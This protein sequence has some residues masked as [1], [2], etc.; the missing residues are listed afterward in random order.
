MGRWRPWIK[1]N[2]KNVIEKLVPEPFPSSA[3][4]ERILH[5]YYI[6]MTR[7]EPPRGRAPQQYAEDT[8]DDAQRKAMYAPENAEYMRERFEYSYEKLKSVAAD[9]YGIAKSAAGKAAQYAEDTLEDAEGKAQYAKEKLN[10]A[11]TDAYVKA[12]SAADTWDNAQRKAKYAKEKLSDTATAAG[13]AYEKSK[14][15][16]ASAYEKDEAAA[17]K[18]TE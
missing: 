17:A 15:V 16:A 9:A 2:E 8:W 14:P 6:F 12:K 1:A 11:A 18:T 7:K 3:A 4:Y 13:D 10:N 5:Y